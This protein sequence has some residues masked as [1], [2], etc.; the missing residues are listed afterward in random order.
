MGDIFLEVVVNFK[1]MEIVEL[2]KLP[3]RSIERIEDE[4]GTLLGLV[5]KNELEQIIAH[6]EPWQILHMRWND[7]AG[8]EYGSSMIRVVS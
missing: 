5:Q 8:Q 2:K 6:F 1:S 4:Y 7:F 3:A